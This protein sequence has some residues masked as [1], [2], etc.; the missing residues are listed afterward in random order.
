MKI[1]RYNK[2]YKFFSSKFNPSGSYTGNYAGND[3]VPEQDVDD[4]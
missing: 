4:L 3:F 1:K 2:K